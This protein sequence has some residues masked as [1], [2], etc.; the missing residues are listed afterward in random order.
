MLREYNSHTP[1]AEALDPSAGP[2]V[3]FVQSHVSTSLFDLSPGRHPQGASGDPKCA[4]STGNIP[5]RTSSGR[6]GWTLQGFWEGI[7]RLITFPER[8]RGT[9]PS[10]CVSSNSNV[11][12]PTIAPYFL[13]SSWA[14]V[15]AV[16]IV[17][18]SDDGWGLGGPFFEEDTGLTGNGNPLIICDF[19][20]SRPTTCFWCN[21]PNR[22]PCNRSR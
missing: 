6:P 11:S 10:S 5:R 20:K 12:R 7:D 15:T 4:Y 8:S 22:K 13:G 17:L 1:P 19:A 21:T 14:G 16:C 3:P 18:A 2:R 9:V